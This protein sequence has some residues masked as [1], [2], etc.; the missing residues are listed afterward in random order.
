MTKRPPCL[1]MMLLILLSFVRAARGGDATGTVNAV[2]VNRDWGGVMV[3]LNIPLT[4]NYEAGCPLGN[5][6]FLPNTDP[7]YNSML[8]TL[9]GAKL[10]GTS[11]RI[12][13]AGCV[14]TPHGLAPLILWIDLGI[15]AQ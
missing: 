5:W 12:F 1:V 15:R 13:T 8:A 10:S 14:N 4:Q 9:I 11:A 6:A 2:N 3:Q 7:F